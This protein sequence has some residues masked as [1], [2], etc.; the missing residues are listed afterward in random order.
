MA[1]RYFPARQAARLDPQ[2]AAARMMNRGSVNMRVLIISAD[3]FEDT[4]L[5]VPYYR[6]QEERMAVDV[7]SLERGRLKGK[8]GYEALAN[9]SIA[10]VQPA[11]YDAL[12]LPGGQAPKSLCES[13]RVLEVVRAFFEADKPVFAICHGPQILVSAGVLRGRSATCY[14]AIGSELKQAGVQ[15]RDA[16][17]VVDGSLVTSREPSDLPAFLREIMKKLRE[18]QK[19]ASAA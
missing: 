9:V 1:F 19:K 15:Y 16:E 13:P 7:A 17:V 14:K 6:F 10:E 2:D 18:Q 12:L 3:C 4:E 11:D 5:L 8:H